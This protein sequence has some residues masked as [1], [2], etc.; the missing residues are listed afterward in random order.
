MYEAS[1]VCI[2]SSP[3]RCGAVVPGV[4]ACVH[5]Y[6]HMRVCVDVYA[7]C[8]D[9]R[10]R[11]CVRAHAYARAPVYAYMRTRMHAHTCARVCTDGGSWWRRLGVLGDVMG[12]CT[13]PCACACMC[14]CMHVHAYM[15]GRVCAWPPV[16][17]TCTLEQVF[18]ALVYGRVCTLHR[19]VFT[20]RYTSVTHSLQVWDTCVYVYMCV[21]G[22]VCVWMR[23]CVLILFDTLRRCYWGFLSVHA[24]AYAYICLCVCVC[25]CM[26]ACVCV[27][28]C[29]YVFLC[30]RVHVRLCARACGC[31]KALV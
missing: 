13:H 2:S 10:R 30:I 7:Y 25:A 18:W 9:M 19:C 17:V 11:A 29:M 28:V 23:V 15:H 31:T 20:P 26:G 8:D 16:S 6:I 21:Y 27:C 22:Y 12:V 5:A 4:L 14:M 1:G 3:C 24:C